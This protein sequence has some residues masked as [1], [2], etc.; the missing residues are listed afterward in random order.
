MVNRLVYFCFLI[1]ISCHPKIPTF[2]ALDDNH[3][4]IQWRSGGGFTG[5]VNTYILTNK[6]DIYHQEKNHY[7]HV[8]RLSNERTQQVFSNIK[9]LGIDQKNYNNPGNKYYGLL[10]KEKTKSNDI[11]WSILDD[12]TA[13]FKLLFDRLNHE[14]NN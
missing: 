2:S 4:Y 13:S 10:Y 6:G 12:E 1:Y 9:T 7:I 8:K 11:I 14:L 5:H 3:T